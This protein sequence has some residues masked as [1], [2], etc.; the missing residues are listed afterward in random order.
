MWIK[1]QRQWCALQCRT[2]S[3]RYK[4]AA[5]W[6]LLSELVQDNPTL[7]LI[8]NG[9][10]LTHYEAADRWELLPSVFG[11]GKQVYIQ[12]ITAQHSSK[13]QHSTAPA[14][15]HAHAQERHRR[16]HSRPSRKLQML[17][18]RLHAVQRMCT[19][20]CGTVQSGPCLVL[21][22]SCHP[23]PA[24]VNPFSVRLLSMLLLLC[25][26]GRGLASRHSWLAGVH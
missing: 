16:T 12:E 7:S 23:P 21:C 20:L 6:T 2:L 14:S 9:D 11:V 8:G 4:K 26:G 24:R 18:V 17:P 15:A 5:D 19:V 1:T 13:L 10:I 25:A 22:S 3:L